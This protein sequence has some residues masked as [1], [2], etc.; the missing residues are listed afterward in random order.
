MD[1]G[2][3]HYFEIKVC[4]GSLLKIGVT[5]S[6]INFEKQAFCDSSNGW[7]IYNGELRHGGFDI[8]GQKYG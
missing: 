6:N 3:K 4:K 1:G 8:K 5:R 7:G 2:S